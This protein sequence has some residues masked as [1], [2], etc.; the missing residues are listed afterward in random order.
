MGNGAAF[1]EQFVTTA[2]NVSFIVR[3]YRYES[4][5]EYLNLTS[6]FV[7]LTPDGIGLHMNRPR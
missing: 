1:N 3:T 5:P 4:E 7:I 2:F 6:P